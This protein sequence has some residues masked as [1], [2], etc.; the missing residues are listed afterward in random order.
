VGAMEVVTPD[1]GVT[2]TI[3]FKANNLV[4]IE[5]RSPEGWFLQAIR[6]C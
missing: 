5:I 2:Q 6:W 4:R 1:P 3:K